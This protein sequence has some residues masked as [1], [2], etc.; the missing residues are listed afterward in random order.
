MML[1]IVALLLLI[2]TIVIYYIYYNRNKEHFQTEDKSAEFIRLINDEYSK[3]I[4]YANRI[5]E[6]KKN[7][8]NLIKDIDGGYAQLIDPYNVF[9]TSVRMNGYP[10]IP[11]VGSFNNIDYKKLEDI[12]RQECATQ[13][14]CKAYS[15]GHN[16]ETQQY[17]YSL[18]NTDD[19]SKIKPMAQSDRNRWKN[20]F[21]TV[22]RT[23]P[24]SS[25]NKL[26]E[27]A[28][29]NYLKAI[30]AS[31]N[32]AKELTQNYEVYENVVPNDFAEKIIRTFIGSSIEFDKN[33]ISSKVTNNFNKQDILVKAISACNKTKKCK[34]ILILSEEQLINN[35][36]TIKYYYYQLSI[37][38]TDNLQDIKTK[39]PNYK[40]T[41]TYLSRKK[42]PVDTKRSTFG[43]S[44]ISDKSK[45]GDT[46]KRTD[47]PFNNRF[48]FEIYENADTLRTNVKDVI[49]SK[50]EPFN[51]GEYDKMIE[52][53]QKACILDRN[54]SAFVAAYDISNSTL[55]YSLKKDDTEDSE[56]NNQ[57]E[58][59][60][61]T[62]K[63]YIRPVTYVKVTYTPPLQMP[64]KPVDKVCANVNYYNHISSY[65]LDEQQVPT[66]GE[67]R[68][69]ELQQPY[70]HEISMCE[71]LTSVTGEDEDGRFNLDDKIT[72]IN[73]AFNKIKGLSPS[74]KTQKYDNNIKLFK[75]LLINIW[76]N[77][78]NIFFADS[79]N[80]GVGNTSGYA[81]IPTDGS[82]DGFNALV[83]QNNPDTKLGI[84]LENLYENCQYTEYNNFG[85]CDKSK[86]YD[87]L[88]KLYV[89]SRIL[90]LG[91]P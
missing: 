6:S 20:N 71:N 68:I 1:C 35:K 27:D 74:L 60:S 41:I 56:N 59:D 73:N 61:T 9:E 80:V 57:F 62:L 43:G 3:G 72:T 78:I 48:K 51:Q 16:S 13:N 4:D 42:I 86:F 2:I 90:D 67:N 7:N 36:V 32:K 49:V 24:L 8:Y 91:L 22:L 21:K 46:S 58:F 66:V 45:R 40:G 38:N 30:N 77:S 65:C 82:T 88:Q 17:I 75:K 52:E 28:S 23:S 70:K 87:D 83:A 18:F 55:F 5:E 85:Y 76:N 12:A 33:N 29:N 64:P 84:L 44:Y 79:L 37:N 31:G 34:G 63:K 11:I 81:T 54:C 25:Y 14:N 15:I 10:K 53:A 26:L 89:T 69:C 50:G 19:L 47:A 39:L